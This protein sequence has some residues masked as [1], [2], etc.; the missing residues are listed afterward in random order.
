LETI[1]FRV[2]LIAFGTDYAGAPFA[3]WREYLYLGPLVA[4]AASIVLLLRRRYTDVLLLWAPLATAIATLGL[5]YVEPRYVRYAALTYLLAAGLVLDA[6]VVWLVYPLQRA[7]VH[8]ARTAAVGLMAG[9]GVAGLWVSVPD[10][11]ALK[12]LARSAALEPGLAKLATEL[13][14]SAFQNVGNWQTTG[15]GARMSMTDKGLIKVIPGQE[16]Y[17]AMSRIDAQGFDSVTY[18]YE[19][20]AE[21]GSGFLGVLS[22]DGSRFRMQE[23]LTPGPSR[24]E[25]ATAAIDDRLIHFVITTSGAP[26]SGAKLFTIKSLR[27]ALWCFGPTDRIRANPLLK[28]RHELFPIS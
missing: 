22:G 12:S 26:E 24:R 9:I 13:D 14:E 27:Q 10:I 3:G 4:M 23:V 19:V 11:L 16:G 28:A 1:L 25:Q 8:L 15:T 17:Q 6:V 20:E 21:G 18:R 7:P 2:K 5:I